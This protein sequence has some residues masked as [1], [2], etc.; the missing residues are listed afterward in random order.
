MT[1]RDTVFGL[2]EATFRPHVAQ[3]APSV[4]PQQAPSASSSANVSPQVP[5]P[6]ARSK[7]APRAAAETK[8]STPAP[9]FEENPYGLR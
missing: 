6:K 4:L 7:R 1:T 8:R 3:P 9:L 5:S 2:D